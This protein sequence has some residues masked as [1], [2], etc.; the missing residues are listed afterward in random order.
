MIW[1][2]LVALEP[3]EL[4]SA[5]DS[6]DRGAGPPARGSSAT[7]ASKVDRILAL[8]ESYHLRDRI[9]RSSCAH[10]QASDDLPPSCSPSAPPVREKRPRD[11]ASTLR[12]PSVISTPDNPVHLPAGR[13]GFSTASRPR[14]KLVPFRSVRIEQGT[15]SRL[16]L[17][18]LVRRSLPKRPKQ[19]L[20]NANTGRRMS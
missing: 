1:W 9:W 2:S 11:A 5:T 15:A 20:P 19:R 4:V 18:P 6:S 14:L 12:R 10:D 8:D 16:W 3:P 7:D 13:R 17:S